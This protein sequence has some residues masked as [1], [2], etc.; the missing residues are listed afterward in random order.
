MES[1]PGANVRIRK[2]RRIF[3]HDEERMTLLDLEACSGRC[4]RDESWFLKAKGLFRFAADQ[5]RHRALAERDDVSDEDADDPVLCP[6]SVLDL[7]GSRRLRDLDFPAVRDDLIVRL[8]STDQ[9]TEHD[10]FRDECVRVGQVKRRRGFIGGGRHHDDR[11]RDRLGRTAL[12]AEREGKAGTGKQP[13]RYAAP[14][15]RS[16]PSVWLPVR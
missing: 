3:Q 2:R 14:A 8:G 15:C 10:V 12:S 16:R 11:H 13:G 1:P 9:G 4:P 7:R 5:H 6:S